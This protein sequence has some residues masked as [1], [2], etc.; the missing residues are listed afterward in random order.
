MVPTCEG[1]TEEDKWKT[2]TSIPIIDCQLLGTYN[3]N[4]KRVVRVTFLYMKHKSCLL[5]R[6]RNLPSGIYVD[7]AYPDII[8]QKRASLQPIL[9]L[10]LRTEG[11]K[12]KCKLDRDQLIIKGSKYNID[13]LHKL[14]D[15]LALYKANQKSNK[16]CLIFHGQHTPLSNFHTSPFIIE[17]K[18]FSSSEQYI[19]YK[20]A[21]HF[22]DYSTAEKIKQSKYPINAKTLSRNITNYDR[23]A[24]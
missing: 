6:K 5:S 9:K 20:K 4:K 7:E 13:T 15:D 11:Y 21:C 22:H 18:K 19:Q 17:D 23:D 10:A 24:W 1:S 2:S 12:G 14:P 16:E 3:R 8:K